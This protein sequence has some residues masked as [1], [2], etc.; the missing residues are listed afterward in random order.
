MRPTATLDPSR[1]GPIFAS[2]A[3]KL[4]HLSLRYPMAV[5]MRFAVLRIDIEAKAQMFK[6]YDQTSEWYSDVYR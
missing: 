2:V 1:P 3:E 4:L 6:S 5:D